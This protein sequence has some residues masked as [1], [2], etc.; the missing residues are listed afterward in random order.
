MIRGIREV[1]VVFVL[2]SLYGVIPPRQSYAAYPGTSANTPD[3][4]VAFTFAVAGG[5]GITV[6]TVTDLVD[7]I[8]AVAS[9]NQRIDDFSSAAEFFGS[10]QMRVSGTW[11]GKLEYAYLINSYTVLG[12][13]GGADYSVD[14]SYVIHMPTAAA[15]YL[16]MD[17]GYAFKFGVGMGYYVALLSESRLGTSRNFSSRGLGVKFDAEANTTLD[18]HLFVYL[19]GDVRLSIMGTLKDSRG[20]ALQLPGSDPSRVKMNFLALGLK[21]GMIYYF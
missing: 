20:N 17:K 1:T 8:N 13:N 2:S 10:A 19:G 5:M 6:I 15:Q 9:S 21:F 7:Y 14:Y 11:G 18:E 16:A 3:D 12:G 4:S